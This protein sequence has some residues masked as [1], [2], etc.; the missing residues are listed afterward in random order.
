MA[1]NR[2]LE[3]TSFEA[4]LTIDEGSD[5]RLELFRGR[6]FTMMATS[7]TH[8]VV[9]ANLARLCGNALRGKDCRFVGENAKVRVPRKGSGYHP[10]GTIACPLRFSNEAQGVV[11]SPQIVFE[12][13]SP[14]TERFDRTDKWDDYA[15]VETIR[16]IVLIEIRTARV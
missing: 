16:E 2:G 11:E 13:L 10:D 15:S 3:E 12:I 9:Q 8:T 4:Y 14:G 1:A 6:V 7:G 5:E